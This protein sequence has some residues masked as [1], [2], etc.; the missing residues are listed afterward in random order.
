MPRNHEW[1]FKPPFRSE[2]PI[3]LSPK[4]WR[5]QAERCRRSAHRTDNRDAIA[6]LNAMARDLERWAIQADVERI[7]KADSGN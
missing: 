5:F 7:V 2:D 3:M 4:F 1:L 6:E